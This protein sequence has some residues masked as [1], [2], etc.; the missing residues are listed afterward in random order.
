V[1]AYISNT[2]DKSNPPEQLTHQ[3]S[4]S[5]L[6]AIFSSNVPKVIPLQKN[7]V[8]GNWYWTVAAVLLITLSATA[9]LLFP[10]STRDQDVVAVASHAAGKNK[11]DVSPGTQGAMLTLAD[12]SVIV[13]DSAGDG[14]LANQG[15]TRI[16]KSGGAVQYIAEAGANNNMLS[17]N[18]IATPRCRQ[19]QL[20]L[21]DG[22]K[23]WLNA[24]SSIRFPAAFD[25]NERHVDITGEVYF[26]VAKNASRPFTV[27]VK[28]MQVQVL[29]THFNINAYNDEPAIN[30]TLLE[31]SVK[32]T[33]HQNVKMLVP[34]QQAKLED[35]GAL[36]V[37]K[38]V[39][40]SEIIAWKNDWFSFHDTDI[41]S[42]MRQISRWYDVAVELPQNLDG[43][44]FNGKISQKS[45]LS[46]VL[47]MLE[48]T[49]E[50]SFSIEGKKVIVR[51]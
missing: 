51:P 32:V 2:W 34:G 8:G 39:N 41:K 25:K 26:E 42:L 31:G 35:D 43:V 27:S 11:N 22:T 13:L 30:T 28:G 10:H 37:I 19:F 48:L 24:E 45:N 18:T 9:W 1:N 21:E 33:N 7:R 5:I 47:T 49:D 46:D 40:T 44:S 4:A 12:G 38:D 3:Q 17:Y 50:V 14:R 6:S 36:R 15:N 23:V 20:V 16:L 29:G